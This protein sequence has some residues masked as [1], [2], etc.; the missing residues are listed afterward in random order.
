MAESHPD[1]ASAEPI[2]F[3]RNASLYRSAYLTLQDKV[4]N[5]V[6]L[7]TRGDRVTYR[8]RMAMKARRIVGESGFQRLGFCMPSH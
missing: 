3:L 7:F 6:P 1:P 4:G 8:N 2:G 5:R